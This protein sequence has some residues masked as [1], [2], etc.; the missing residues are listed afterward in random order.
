MY[1][2]VKFR[3]TYNSVDF[4]TMNVARKK[5]NFW[6]C[7][8]KKHDLQRIGD[9][10]SSWTI[11]SHQESVCRRMSVNSYVFLYFSN[12][13][14]YFF[15]TP[16]R[17]TI[18]LDENH[19]SFITFGLKWIW[20]NSGNF[21]KF[22]H[23]NKKGVSHLFRSK[24][25]RIWML[26]IFLITTLERYQWVFRKIE[27]FAEKYNNRRFAEYNSDFHWIFGWW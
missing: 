1:F 10:P 23:P 26:E 18:F 25:K 7:S 3:F 15:E 6:K 13:F 17:A 21:A 5:H 2:Y 14:C 19:G 9:I 27:Y 24:K 4:K 16:I 11:M 22:S 8:L 12:I 20:S